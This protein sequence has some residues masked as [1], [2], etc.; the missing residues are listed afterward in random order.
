MRGKQFYSGIE[1]RV[2]AIACFAPQRTVADFIYSTKGTSLIYKLTSKHPHAQFSVVQN[3]Q[4]PTPVSQC[5]SKTVF[6]SCPKLLG[7]A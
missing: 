4:W 2:W 1:I 5:R 6:P 3:R 7:L